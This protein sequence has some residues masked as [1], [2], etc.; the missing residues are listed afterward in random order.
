MFQAA[1]QDLQAGRYTAAEIGFREVVRIDPHSAAAYANLGVVYLRTNRFREAVGA[2]DRAAQLGPRVAGI[3]LNLG[4]AYLRQEQ[5]PQAIGHFRQ[6]AE[7]RPQQPQPQYLLG[8]SQYMTGNCQEA[9]KTLQPL[10]TQF[11]SHMDYLYMLGSCHGKNGDES[12]AAR[13]FDQMFQVEGDS[14]RVHW[15]LGNAYLT[16]QVNQKA[17]DELEKARADPTLPYLHYSLALAYYRL[18]KTT[19]AL[20]ALEEEIRRNPR[21]ASSYGLRGAIYLDLRELDLSIASYRK[22]L[23][24]KPEQAA[25]YYGLGR[26]YLLKGDLAAATK[27]LERA[28]TLKPDDDNVHFQLGEA[29]RRAGRKQEA[30]RELA[31]AQELQAAT[32]KMLEQKVM[33]DLPPSPVQ[34]LAPVSQP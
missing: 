7:L 18:R 5:F 4:L 28:A 1:E 15:L 16:Q 6:A 32:R 31:R 27:D 33:G 25:A 9:A 29:Y 17:V 3:Q 13:V 24:L 34:T 21:Y 11:S 8:L 2:L 26:A 23:E 10:Y 30:A 22:S 14:P 20:A 19:E 12:Q